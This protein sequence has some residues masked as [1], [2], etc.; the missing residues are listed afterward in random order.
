[1]GDDTIITY[2]TIVSV[3]A[4]EIG[5][6]IL[7]LRMYLSRLMTLSIAYNEISLV[8]EQNRREAGRKNKKDLNRHKRNI[9]EML[10]VRNVSSPAS[11]SNL[12]WAQKRRTN[13]RFFQLGLRT[14]NTV[15][16]AVVSTSII[17]LFNGM[18]Q[19]WNV[20]D[21]VFNTLAI[22][23]SFSFGDTLYSKLCFCQKC[24]YR[25]CIQCCYCCCAPQLMLDQIELEP[26]NAKQMESNKDGKTMKTED[27]NANGDAAQDTKLEL[28]VRPAS[29][30]EA[31]EVIST[32]STSPPQTKETAP[33][34]D[35]CDGKE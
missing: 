32:P 19:W 18:G 10:N 29:T 11:P 9:T 24:C 31:V 21:C 17:T 25:F 2:I 35:E 7:V 16:L 26:K 20:M 27:N 30:A 15:I 12:T 22:Y 6:S 23:L 28:E 1:M 3:V 8:M 33:T 13:A 34:E 14:T 5:S 4:C